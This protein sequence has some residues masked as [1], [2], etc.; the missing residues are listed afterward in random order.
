MS[1][2]NGTAV[3]VGT[4]AGTLIT[5]LCLAKLAPGAERLAAL[6]D[7]LTA[8]PCAVPEA[9]RAAHEAFLAVAT[10]RDY[11]ESVAGWLAGRRS[12][13]GPLT[14]SP[15]LRQRLAWATVA[16]AAA[17]AVLAA[18]AEYG[19]DPAVCAAR[20]CVSACEQVHG[21]AAVFDARPG[22]VHALA[23]RRLR[24]ASAGPRPAVSRNDVCERLAARLPALTDGD[25]AA[26][27]RRLVAELERIR[28]VTATT[29]RDELT[30]AEAMARY[31]TPGLVG[32]V[33]AHRNITATFLAGAGAAPAAAALLPSAADGSVLTALAVTEPHAG[34]DLA[35][36]TSSVRHNGP[37]LVLE[38]TKT[39]VTGGA[40]AD[41]LL[42]AART[43]VAGT[44]LVW[45]D[46]A[47]PGVTRLPLAGRAWQDGGIA[48][49]DIRSY[50]VPGRAVHPG[51]GA[52]AL[53]H[54][55]GRERLMLA[56]QQLAYAR[57]W[58]AEL[59]GHRRDLADRAAA[60]G[61]L[62][63]Q[64]VAGS[65]TPSLVDCGM[66]KL[67]CCEVAVDVAEARLAQ[68]STVDNEAAAGSLLEDHAAARAATVAAGT[69]DL[70]LAI[71]EGKVTAMFRAGRGGPP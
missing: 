44:V 39:Y 15:V 12:F 25:A 33:L 32:R 16:L 53:L 18:P 8:G 54:G 2:R 38:G 57:R 14:E 22:I 51:D 31:L 71:V 70:N 43:D 21:A 66:V 23:A 34:S 20:D 17:D 55:L 45:V 28:P 60:A 56:A 46:P 5:R 7:H 9:G 58:L 59:P 63:R 27:A 62:L 48:R 52:S 50:E 67:A 41:A 1:G 68:L 42:V 3:A 30:V 6:D 64:A 37:T 13:G 35:G 26:R 19:V 11:L 36:L 24:R 47:R 4:D 49:L 65:G 61:A 69:T 29:L 10:A 40:D